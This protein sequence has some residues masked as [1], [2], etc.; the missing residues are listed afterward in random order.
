LQ[1]AHVL[2]QGVQVE[3]QGVQGV[4]VSPRAPAPAAAP[5]RPLWRL[6]LTHASASCIRQHTSAY[7][8]IRQHTLWRWRLTHASCRAAARTR[9]AFMRTSH[10]DL[11]LRNAGSSFSIRQ[12]KSA[13]V[14]IRQHTS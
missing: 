11:Q 3:L 13:F 1:A 2:L 4:Q 7:A 8:S 14:S 6:R 5:A 10:R 9:G 12:H